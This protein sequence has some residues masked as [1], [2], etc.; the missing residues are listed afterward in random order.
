MKTLS[1][2]SQKKISQQA[3]SV[4]LAT[5]QALTLAEAGSKMV[6]KNLCTDA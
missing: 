2:A 6:E 4:A 1:Q 5:S 3:E